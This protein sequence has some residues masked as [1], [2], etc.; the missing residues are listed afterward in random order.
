MSVTLACWTAIERDWRLGMDD[1]CPACRAA[2]EIE[3]Q[4]ATEC[5]IANLRASGWLD[6]MKD[7]LT[8]VKD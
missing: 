3:E 2:A 1:L 4:A 6:S 8:P 5:A 7:G